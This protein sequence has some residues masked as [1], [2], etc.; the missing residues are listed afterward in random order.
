MASSGQKFHL[1]FLSVV[2]VPSAGHVG[3]LLVTNQLG[4]PLEFQCTTPV[5]PNRT[6][7]ILYGPTLR[8]FLLCDLIGKTL[9]ERLAVKPQLIVVA[10]ADFLA[11]RTHVPTPVA[12]ASAKE[13]SRGSLKLGQQWLQFHEQYAAEDI[14]ALQEAAKLIVADCDLREPIERVREA[15]E[16]TLKAGAAA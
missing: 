11:L 3:G 13:S 4:R 15:L 6:Q 16:E 8:P 5:R 1:G 12:V 14:A 7:E 10:D 2:E 9:F